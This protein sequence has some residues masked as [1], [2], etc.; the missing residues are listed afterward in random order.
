MTPNSELINPNEFI[1]DTYLIANFFIEIEPESFV[2]DKFGINV[3]KSIE[4]FKFLQSKNFIKS[5]NLINRS[6]ELNIED[7][8]DIGPDFGVNDPDAVNFIIKTVL[9]S[10]V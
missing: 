1:D 2:N 4:I 6:M 8:K 10:E 7:L 9:D 3:Q 5:D